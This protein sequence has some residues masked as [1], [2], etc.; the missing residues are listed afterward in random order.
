MSGSILLSTVSN[1]LDFF[2]METG[3]TLDIVCA[4][5]NP[6]VRLSP[7]SLTSII[8]AARM[9]L[10]LPLASSAAAAADTA[11]W[12]LACMAVHA[13]ASTHAARSICCMPG[14]PSGSSGLLLFCK[15]QMRL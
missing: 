15:P 9:A 10:S 12:S 11:T 7:H 2:K 8:V 14:R 5:I 3:K 6:R 4:E 13:A 1:F